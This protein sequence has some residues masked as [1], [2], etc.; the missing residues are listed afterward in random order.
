MIAPKEEFDGLLAKSGVSLASLDI[1]DIGLLRSDA[2]RAV[3][4]LRHGKLPILGG[5]VYL[6]RGDRIE[7]A[8]A[9]W[10]TNP[11]PEEDC[12]TYLRR[13]WDHTATYIKNFPEFP[14]AEVLF[15]LVV[16]RARGASIR[17]TAR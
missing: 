3:E 15:G 16:E 6:R 1:R 9:N 5:D 8:Y 12:E 4:I 10:Y 2:L 17:S 13:S 14:D 11:K 7:V